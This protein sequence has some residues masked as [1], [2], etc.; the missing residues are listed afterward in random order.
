MHRNP[1]SAIVQTL[2][3]EAKGARRYFVVSM[4]FNLE[5]ITIFKL[6]LRDF[7]YNHHPGAINRKE[8]Y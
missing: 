6:D 2:Y 4:F 8:N 5:M 7:Q 1:P 3:S